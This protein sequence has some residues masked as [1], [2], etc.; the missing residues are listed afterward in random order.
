MTK[1]LEQAFEKASK[2]PEFEQN[3]LSRWLL[4][5]IISEKKWEK[6]FAESEDM[7]DKLAD[8]ALL[9]YEKRKLF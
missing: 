3:A 2:L 1:L 8:E 7:L 6:I 5:E 4:D 9:E